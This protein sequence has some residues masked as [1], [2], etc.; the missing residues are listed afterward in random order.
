MI[1]GYLPF[2]NQERLHSGIGY[3]SPVQFEDN[4]C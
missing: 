2:Y 1:K 4:L 3:Q